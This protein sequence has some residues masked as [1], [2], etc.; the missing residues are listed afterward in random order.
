MVWQLDTFLMLDIAVSLHLRVPN[1]SLGDGTAMKWW[2]RVITQ[3]QESRLL[4]LLD[5]I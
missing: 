4:I 2:S 1:G 5:K 3:E